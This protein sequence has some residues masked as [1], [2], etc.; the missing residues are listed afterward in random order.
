MSDATGRGQ[1]RQTS[2][3][4]VEQPDREAGI[5]RAGDTPVTHE[6]PEDWWWHGEAGK[7]GRITGWVMVVFLLVM[8]VGNHEGRIED[9]YLVLAAGIIVVTLL[10]DVR[11]RK[12]SWRMR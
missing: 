6:R 8:M 12:N 11:R 2:A 9:I 10:W 1:G 3:E 5:V 4:V 7:A